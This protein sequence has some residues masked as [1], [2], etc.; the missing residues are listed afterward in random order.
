M[1]KS[2]CGN[3][4]S[5]I[6]LAGGCL[7]LMNGFTLVPGSVWGASIVCLVVWNVTRK[8]VNRYCWRDLVNERD[9]CKVACPKGTFSI[10]GMEHCEPYLT[11]AQIATIR[12][13]GQ[14]VGGGAVKKVYKA[15]WKD[16]IVALSILS[17]MRHRDDFQHNIEMHHELARP[18]MTVDYLGACGNTL[19]TEF[20]ELGS[21]QNLQ[22][23]LTRT[24]RSYDTVKHRLALCAGY[25]AIL[26][27]LHANHRVMCDSNWLG[28]ILSQYLI[29]SDLTLRIND[30]DALPLVTNSKMPCGRQPLQGDLLA[31]EQT[32]GTGA[33][34][35]PCDIWKVPDV[36]HWF[37]GESQASEAI[38]FHL[39]GLHRQCK[40][41]EP[42]QRPTAQTLVAHYSHMLKE[43]EDTTHTALKTCVFD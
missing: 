2:G 33:C 39:F 12:V 19:V 9:Q 15:Q 13:L 10:P 35:T 41:S 20:Y 4:P 16:Y 24:L 5:E 18:N 3:D 11:C 22:T 28:K 21:A 6:T 32:V 8:P 42:S 34:S 27:H 29:H 30:M 38:K 36:C 31:P 43:M 40:L 17:D 23:L 14:P 1:A 37:L 26:A 25:A 7:Q